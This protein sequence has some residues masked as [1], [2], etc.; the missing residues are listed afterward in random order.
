MWLVAGLGFLA[1]SFVI[2]ISFF[3]PA[4][5]KIGSP[6]FYIAFIASGLLILLALPLIIY[7]RKKPEW[8]ETPIAEV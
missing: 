4:N 7:A 3:P 1:M 5:L 2:V 8:K 6:L